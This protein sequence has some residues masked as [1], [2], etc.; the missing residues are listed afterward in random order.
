VR[1]FTV[2][3]ALSRA[4]ITWTKYRGFSIGNLLTGKI[5]ASVNFGSYS[6][7]ICGSAPSHG[8][9]V[10][11]SNTQVYVLDSP[12]KQVRV[13]SAAD[14]P[15]LIATINVDGFCAATES[16]T[17]CGGPSCAAEGWL[18]HTLD[19]NYV[20]VGSSGDVINTSTRTL[21][22]SSSSSDNAHQLYTDL[23]NTFH[24]FIVVNW[25]GGAPVAGSHFG[26]GN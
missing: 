23:R 19:G 15:S 2:G 21:A 1:P 24:G 17:Y 11:P 14:T 26:V 6:Q 9:S 20:L 16:S 13:Y 12:Q 8:I 25:S 4:W 18:Q 22:V 7:S 5:L 10:N 3:R